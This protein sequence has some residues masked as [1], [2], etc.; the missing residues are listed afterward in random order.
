ML[1]LDPQCAHRNKKRFWSRKSWKTCF[2]CKILVKPGFL[3]VQLVVSAVEE[4]ICQESEKNVT[5]AVTAAVAQLED[6]VLELLIQD[7]FRGKTLVANEV[8]R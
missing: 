3:E 4:S 7:E 1:F 8:I 2:T 6:D 5:P